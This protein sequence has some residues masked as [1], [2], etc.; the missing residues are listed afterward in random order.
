MRDKLHAPVMTEMKNQT[1][2]SLKP[3][4][5]RISKVIQTWRPEDL[6]DQNSDYLDEVDWNDLA[7]HLTGRFTLGL[8]SLF[9]E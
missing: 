5:E 4:L 8:Y 9:W 6:A 3:L 7:E 2:A 1:W